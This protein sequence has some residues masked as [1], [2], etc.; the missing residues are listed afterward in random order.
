[1]MM[2]MIMVMIMIIINQALSKTTSAELNQPAVVL[3]SG[4]L[5]ILTDF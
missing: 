2:I 3:G 5:Y 4:N 1:M